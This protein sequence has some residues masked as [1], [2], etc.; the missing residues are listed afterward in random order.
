ME[1]NLKLYTQ[2]ESN[3]KFSAKDIVVTAVLAALLFSVQVGLSFLPNI[4]L[5]SLLIIIYTLIFKEKAFYAIYIFAF[6]EGAVYGFGVWW[7]MYLYVWTILYAVTY[8]FRR[9]RSVILWAVISGFFGL[10]FGALCAIPYFITGGIGAGIAWWVSGLLF[11]VVHGAG[12]FVVV[13]VLYK[14][15]FCIL[16]KL[17]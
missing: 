13:L 3:K 1:M 17:S 16:E 6:L 9:N 11:D 7:V 2:S 10:S 4:E 5:V 8:L 12:N 14:P 15:I